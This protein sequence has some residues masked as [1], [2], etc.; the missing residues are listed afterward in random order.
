MMISS[1]C[2]FRG[3]HLPELETASGRLL[4]VMKCCNRPF[5]D[6]HNVC[7]NQCGAIPQ[8][9]AN[10]L[11]CLLDVISVNFLGQS[12]MLFF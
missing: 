4:P 1:A 8:R 10:D 2:A 9:K 7:A 12:S 3:G 11:D 5:A 6:V